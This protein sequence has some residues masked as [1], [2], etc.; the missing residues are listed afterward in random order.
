MLDPRPIRIVAAC[1]Q[2][3]GL[4]DG[5]WFVRDEAGAYAGR[6]I[7]TSPVPHAVLSV[8]F[9]QPNLEEG[10]TPVPHASLLGLQSRTRTWS[11]SCETS[12]VMVMLT[13]PGLVRLFPHAGATAGALLD[14]GALVGDRTAHSLG[15]DLR[16]ARDPARVSR[17]LDAWL[18]RR[19]ATITMPPELATIEHAC[20]LLGDGAPVTTVAR[21]AACGRRQLHRWFVRHFGVG[22]KAVM[23]LARM[24]ASVRALQRGDLDDAVAG[25]ADAPHQIRS[26]R[27]QLGTTP[28][29]YA[30]AGPSALARAV[31]DVDAPAFYL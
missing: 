23:E 8:N 9:G 13:L 21:D 12:F 3:R 22:P 2:L 16:A 4:V 29:R 31:T 15:D 1:P 30:Q 17:Q 6:S 18:C 7:T 28:G 26:W 10:R 20:K 25:F 14:L 24:H 27:R 19:S 11:A 5:Y